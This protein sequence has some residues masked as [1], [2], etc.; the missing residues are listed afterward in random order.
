MTTNAEMPMG[1]LDQWGRGRLQVTEKTALL[2]RMGLGVATV[3]RAVEL[4]E[5]LLE[6][7]LVTQPYD[8]AL[9]VGACL[10]AALSD[11]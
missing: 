10:C 1:N 8:S 4:G 5:V 9:A 11:P 2:V 7:H 6:E 3:L